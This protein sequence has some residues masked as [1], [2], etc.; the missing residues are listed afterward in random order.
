MDYLKFVL[1]L[2]LLL[3]SLFLVLLVMIQRGKGGGLAGA[4]G[5]MG[6]YSAFGTRAGDLFTRITIV[7]ASIWILLA[8]ALAK[9][10]LSSS[11]PY[12]NLGAP[13]GAGRPAAASG[14]S[15]DKEGDEAKADSDSSTSGSKSDSSGAKESKADPA[16]VLEKAADAAKESKPSDNP[17]EL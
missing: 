14:E 13:A 16:T 15:T 1:Y 11:Q 3:S 17:S 8:M 4:L 9:M 6:G 7:T 2:L 5:G 12:Q 10:N